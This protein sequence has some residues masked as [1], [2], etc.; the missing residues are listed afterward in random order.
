[1]T[2]AGFAEMR[3]VV[4]D[5]RKAHGAAERSKPHPSPLVRSRSLH[6]KPRSF[7]DL[8]PYASRIYFPIISAFIS[9][10]IISV[11]ICYY[12]PTI[13][14]IMSLPIIALSFPYLFPYHFPVISV[15]I[16]YCLPIYFPI[17]SLYFLISQF[18]P[19]WFPYLFPYYFRNYPI[20]STSISLLICL[21]FPENFSIISLLFFKLFPFK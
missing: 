11:S 18:I 15:F 19:L 9:F 8:F 1:M 12:F 21:L 5:L 4:D 7:T 16:P 10:R 17:I 20:I 6:Q 14:H 2:P 13:F 3:S